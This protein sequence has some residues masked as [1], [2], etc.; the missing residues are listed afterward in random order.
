M[1]QWFTEFGDSPIASLFHPNKDEIWLH[2]SLLQSAPDRFAVFLRKL[3]PQTMPG[4]VD[5]VHLP[6]SQITWKIRI[7]KKWRYL[8]YFCS[9]SLRHV[10]SSSRHS[11][12][13]FGGGFIKEDV[14]SRFVRFLAASAVFELGMFI[15]YLLYNLLLL[16]RGFHEDFLGAVGG[17]M[18]AGGIAGTL[19]A[20]FAAKQWGLK[21]LLV[22]SFWRSR[23]F[24]RC[25]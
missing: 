21:R 18:Q 2:L 22:M 17:T 25:G 24:W 6:D 16:D 23:W 19:P 1:T 7:R 13:G 14:S 8:L 4:P 11:R 5:A 3:V 10:G 20:G 15:F 12:V 9:R